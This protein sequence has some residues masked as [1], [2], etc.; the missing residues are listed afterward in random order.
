[1]NTYPP[2][3]DELCRFE[4]V[5]FEGTTY[6]TFEYAITTNDD[7]PTAWS[8]PATVDGR[9]A[10]PVAGVPVGAHTVWVRVTTPASEHVVINAGQFRIA[11]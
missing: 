9:K 2:E 8:T 7:R 11:P 3:T 1:M 4:S 6:T 5:T 10:F